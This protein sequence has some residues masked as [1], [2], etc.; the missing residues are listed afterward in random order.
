MVLMRFDMVFARAKERLPPVDLETTSQLI[1]AQAIVVFVG[2]A[3]APADEIYKI[4][5]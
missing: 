3:L 1:A 2:L 4:I 5:G